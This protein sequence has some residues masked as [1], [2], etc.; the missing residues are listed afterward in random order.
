MLRRRPTSLFADETTRRLF[1]LAAS[2]LVLNVAARLPVYYVPAEAPVGWLIDLERD[3]LKIEHFALEA[4]ARPTRHV[5]PAPVETADAPADGADESTTELVLREDEAPPP[6]SRPELMRAAVLEFSE[7]APKIVGGLRAFYINIEYPKAAREAGIEGRLV[8]DF[9]VEPDGRPTDIVVAR[10]LHPL[11]DSAAVDALR[12]TRFAPGMHNGEEVRVRMRLPVRFRLID[13]Q[14]E[15]PP[16]AEDAQ[17]S[18]M[19]P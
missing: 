14:T 11:C 3:Q 2:L 19:T 10:S 1:A 18:A 17:E 9:V 12:R 8:L 6:V 16:I 7:I 4:H 13:R 5:A 15:A